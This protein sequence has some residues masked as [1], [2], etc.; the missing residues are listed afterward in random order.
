[1]GARQH[2]I[3]AGIDPGSSKTRMVVL[4]VDRGRVRLVGAGEAESAG[5][6]KGRIADQA[7]VTD[8]VLAALR[9]AEATSGLSVENTVVGLGG[10][11]VRG[12][13][14]H[15]IHNWGYVR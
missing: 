3:G 12:T 13:N 7:A 1:M 5:G 10:P 11:A 9:E 6:A 15:G 8:S 2:I 14:V 4:V